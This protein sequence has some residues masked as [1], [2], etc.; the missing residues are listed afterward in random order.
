MRSPKTNLVPIVPKVP[1]VPVV[2]D[3]P[4]VIILSDC[5]DATKRLISKWNPVISKTKLMT[6]MNFSGVRCSN[7]PAKG[8]III[9]SIMKPSRP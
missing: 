1:V 8:L 5:Q 7:A 6:L 3:L 9:V 4:E 2:E